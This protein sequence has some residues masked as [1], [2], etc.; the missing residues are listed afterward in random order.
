M[1]RSA[2]LLLL[3][4]LL[5]LPGCTML[6]RRLSGQSGDDQPREVLAMAAAAVRE[7]RAGPQGGKF[8]EVLARSRAALVFPDLFKLGV[9]FAGGGGPGVLLARQPDGSFGE[10]AFYTLSSAGWGA[11]AGVRRT[12]LA[13]LFLTDNATRQVLSGDLDAAGEGGLTLAALDAT[14]GQSTATLTCEVVAFSAS[15]GLFGG[16]A[17]DGQALNI[18]RSYNI[19]YHG[20]ALHPAE[21]IALPSRP[22]PAADDLRRALEGR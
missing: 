6:E 12:R 16:V 21:I 20:G 22:D 17:L 2:A 3:C 19:Q 14:Y 4:L 8:A 13:L 11:Q 5:A 9:V 10:P 1:R 15:D 7:L 18:Q